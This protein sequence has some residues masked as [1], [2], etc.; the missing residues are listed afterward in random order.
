MIYDVMFPMERT[1]D[2]YKD[3]LTLHKIAFAVALSSTEISETVLI[4]DIFKTKLVWCQ[5]NWF[6]ESTED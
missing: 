6:G 3:I 5:H 2:V 4:C 1:L